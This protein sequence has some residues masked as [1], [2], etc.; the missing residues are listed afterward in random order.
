MIYTLYLDTANGQKKAPVLN[1]TNIFEVE[2]LVD[3]DF[4]FKNL[5]KI[6]R[7]CKVKIELVSG[8]WGSAFTNNNNTAWVSCSLPNDTQKTSY[9][10]NN[11]VKGTLLGILTPHDRI[12]NVGSG[13][14]AWYFY[15]TCKSEYVST[16]TPHEQNYFSIYIT[17]AN[18]QSNSNLIPSN[19]VNYKVVL[20]FILDDEED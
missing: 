1:T 12:L 17:P 7:R 10:D 18:S 14:N 6:Y 2:W 16:L 15:P 3:W 20:N 4:L 8:F 5:N 19:S 11:G 13:A 9:Q